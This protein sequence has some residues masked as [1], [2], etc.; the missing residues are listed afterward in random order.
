M[1]AMGLPSVCAWTTHLPLQS[2]PKNMFRKNKHLRL[3]KTLK[4]G[5]RTP[6]FP[7]LKKKKISELAGLLVDGATILIFI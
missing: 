6:T 3:P 2:P 4:I 1:E 7:F 5:P